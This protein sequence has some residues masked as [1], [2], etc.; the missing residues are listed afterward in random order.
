RPAV[1]GWLRERLQGATIT[2]SR[3]IISAI[4]DSSCVRLR[5]DD[6]STRVA[7]HVLLGTGYR[8]DISRYNFI[9]P[10]LVDSIV[11][12]DGYPKLDLGFQSSV[13]GLYFTGAPASRSFGPLVRFVSGT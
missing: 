6:E 5:L 1:S 8:V 9:A 3:R 7:D 2:L 11:C 13:Q 12:V 4:A 10:E